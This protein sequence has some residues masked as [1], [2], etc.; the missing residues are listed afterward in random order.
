MFDNMT[1]SEGGGRQALEDL[2][3]EATLKG[4][5]PFVVLILLICGI[6]WWFSTHML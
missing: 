2:R 1:P 5:F 6:A 3:N 4:C